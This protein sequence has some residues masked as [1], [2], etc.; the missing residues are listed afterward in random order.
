MRAQSVLI[1]TISNAVDRVNHLPTDLPVLFA[2]D[3]NLGR[4]VQ[5]QSGRELTLWQDA[6][7]FMRPSA[8]RPFW[9][10]SMNITRLK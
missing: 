4:W 7:S 9:P 8:K 2:P 10:S 5:Q 6:A 1:C 3:Q